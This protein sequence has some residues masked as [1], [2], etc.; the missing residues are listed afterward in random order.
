[1]WLYHVAL[2]KGGITRFIWLKSYMPIIEKIIHQDWCDEDLKAEPNGI[3]IW[4][5]EGNCYFTF[6]SALRE[7][8]KQ[9]LR[10]PSKEDWEVAFE[11]TWKVK[12]KDFLKINFSGYRRWND[13]QYSSQGSYGYYW[14]SSPYSGD[15]YN[16]V[17]SSGGVIAVNNDRGFGFS[18][19]CLKN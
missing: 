10:V 8:E 18:V 2:R 5:H 13:G 1:M 17:F 6:D 3:D 15:A 19:R 4:E 14:S 9:W 16:A 7:A 12:L 11:I